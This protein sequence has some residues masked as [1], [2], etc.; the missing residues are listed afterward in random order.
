MKKIKLSPEEQAIEKALIR[1]EYR[2]V[3]NTE[4]QHIAQAIACRKKDAVLNIRVNHQDLENLK[5]K[6]KRLGVP[7]QSFVSELLHHLAAPN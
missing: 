3:S 4:F 7:Y 1:G 5:K 2:P 6:A